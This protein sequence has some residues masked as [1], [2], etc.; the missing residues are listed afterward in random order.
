MTALRAMTLWAAWQ[1][2]E[3]D[4]MGSLEVGKVADLVILSDDPLSVPEDQLADLQ[5][6]QTIKDGEVVY[7]RGED[8]AALDPRFTPPPLG[9]G[10]G[11]GIA[12]EHRPHR[13][14]GKGFQAEPAWLGHGC[15]ADGCF[16]HA[17]G[18][19]MAGL[20]EARPTTEAPSQDPGHGP[21]RDR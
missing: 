21:E 10:M 11:T 1:H 20:A 15:A 17:V 7:D 5:V 19:I 14:V 18:A 8:R 6:V 4:R 16:S 12:P 2:F 9:G 3:E 13:D